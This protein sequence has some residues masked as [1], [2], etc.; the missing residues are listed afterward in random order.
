IRR[1]RREV[2]R[3]GMRQEHLQRLNHSL[4][5]QN[6]KFDE[7]A[8][9]DALT[10]A[11]NRHGIRDWLQDQA[12]LVRWQPNHVSVLFIDIDYFKQVNDVYGHSL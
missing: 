3:A 12:R 2:L 11:I 1:N 10:G 4:H 8:H 5:E 7:M 6:I 9:R